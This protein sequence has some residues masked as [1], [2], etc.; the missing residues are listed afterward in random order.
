S[1]P[2]VF[3]LLLAAS[4]IALRAFA[5][6]IYGWQRSQASARQ[7][8]IIY[9]AGES[10]IQLTAALRTSREFRPVAFVDDNPALIGNVVAG[11][12]VH[13]P[14]SIERLM[15]RYQVGD[16]LLALPSISRARRKEIISM[17]SQY[18]L[19]VRSVPSMVE[20]VAGFGTV[21]QL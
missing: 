5:T 1:T 19:R 6:S 13:G 3:A 7:P 2:I 20:I 17:L 10:G 4:M 14:Q 8:V 16:I 21:D 12:R 15:A 18:P 9:G 11:Y